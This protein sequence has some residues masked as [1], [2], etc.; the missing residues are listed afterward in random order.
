MNPVVS[1]ERLI[2]RLLAKL[3]DAKAAVAAMGGPAQVAK[4]HARGKLTARERI[5]RFFDTGT[6]VASECGCATLPPTV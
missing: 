4:Q 2:D 1:K 6:F 5:D 3:A